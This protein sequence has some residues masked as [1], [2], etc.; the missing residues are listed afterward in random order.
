MEMDS[1]CQAGC[2]WEAFSNEMK[3]GYKIQMECK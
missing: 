2:K 3:M 1:K